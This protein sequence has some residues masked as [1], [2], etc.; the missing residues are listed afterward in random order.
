MTFKFHADNTIP[1]GDWIWVFASNEAGKHG[2]GQARIAR[3]NFRAEFGVGRG[4]TGHAYAIATQDRHLELLPLAAIENSIGGSLGFGADR[5]G[6]VYGLSLGLLNVSPEEM[7]NRKSQAGNLSGL[8]KN[9]HGSKNP[10][11]SEH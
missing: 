7:L 3:V 10:F 1:S 5:I 8:L 9:G 2:K 11:F 4:P 6:K